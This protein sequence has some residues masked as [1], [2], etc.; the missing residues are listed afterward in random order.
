[1]TFSQQSVIPNFIPVIYA[2]PIKKIRHSFNYAP[3]K[4]YLFLFQT[5]NWVTKLDSQLYPVITTNATSPKDIADHVHRKLET[6]LPEIKRAQCEVEQR[7]RTTEALMARSPPMDE[8]SLNVKN[9]LSEM[10]QK[11]IEITTDY[12]TLLEKLS[13]Y[14]NN[15]TK[16]DKTVDDVN[17]RFSK[18]LPSKL[19]EL[20]TV[21]REHE[22]SKENILEIFKL[23]QDECHNV[24]NRINKQV[25]TF[26][27]NKAAVICFC[28]FI[29]VIRKIEKIYYRRVSVNILG[30]SL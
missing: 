11:L 30:F 18:A 29:T 26:H 7:I 6:V 5:I 1:M 20:E 28:F 10:N 19:I 4:S 14:F 3:I 13:S 17:N 12:Q 8:R 21:I 16:L 9:K 27:L 23:R 2:K 15:L 25:C 22:I 24:M